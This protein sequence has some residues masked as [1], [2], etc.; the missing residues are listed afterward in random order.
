VL[1]PA[2]SKVPPPAADAELTELRQQME[3]LKKQLEQLQR[4]IDELEGRRRQA[5][6]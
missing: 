6:G 3:T 2:D 5:G 4:R 1:V